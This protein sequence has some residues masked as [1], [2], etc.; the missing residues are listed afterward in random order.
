MKR[1]FIPYVSE[2]DPSVNVSDLVSAREQI[3]SLEL[4]IKAYQQTEIEN[5]EFAAYYR[6]LRFSDPDVGPA[7]MTAERIRGGYG[8]YQRQLREMEIEDVFPLEEAAHA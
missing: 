8:C 3:N 6:F 4:K 2:T 7:V 5:A 1:K